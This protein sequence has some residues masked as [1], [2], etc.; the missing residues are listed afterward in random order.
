MT[1]PAVTI[2]DAIDYCADNIAELC[3]DSAESI[4]TNMN[5]WVASLFGAAGIFTDTENNGQRRVIDWRGP[6]NMANESIEGPLA[7]DC[8]LIGC[9]NVID[10]V[11]R[12]LCAVR[13]ATAAGATSGPQQTA[14][15]A[16]F[17]TAWT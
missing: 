4:K 17:N 13:D 16:A 9:S 15:I 6:T 12:T 7:G 11:V 10:A 1:T 14:T 2:Q 3:F 5:T 8:G